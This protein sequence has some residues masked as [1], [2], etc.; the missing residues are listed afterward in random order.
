L[1]DTLTKK[2]RRNRA[3]A[4]RRLVILGATGSIGRSVADVI[5]ANPDS[6]VVEALVGGSNAPAL[7]KMAARLKARFAALADAAGYRQLAD[8]LA[9]TGV[10]AAA[11]PSAVVEAATR[12]SDLVVAAIVGTAGVAP[13][14]AA[15]EAG[16]T[17]ALANK[18]SLVCA[19]Y[20]F[21]EAARR[22]GV[23]VLPMDSEHNAI[24]QCLAGRSSRDVAK[25]TLTASGGP[26]RSW[27]AGRIAAA[28]CEEAVAHP[29][30]SMGAKISVDSAT[31]MNKGLELIEAHH[32][33]NIDSALLD[34]VVHP[35][36]I[37]HGLIE[38]RDGAVIAG[39]ANPDMRI[40]IAHC[41][42]YPERLATQATRLDLAQIG[43]LTF[44]Q[45]DYDR[46]PALGLARAALRHGDGMPTVLNAANE[47]AVA[48]FLNRRI[49]FPDIARTVDAACQAAAADGSARRPATVADALAVDHVV[50][51]RTAASLAV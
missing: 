48:A 20:P 1:N 46:F 9:G 42:G 34:V 10:A 41:L 25:M 13:T 12:P 3:G 38:F 43:A 28:T 47:I 26:F 36:S 8:L 45:P 35:Q 40:P 2:G 32:I 39:L 11:G 33:F 22:T 5:E 14:F 31:L 17:I 19:G 29:N 4:P 7:A 50:R 51:E 27:D 6:F 21:M 23:R 15:L 44:E 16:R 24:F 37:V 18:E 49:G 30:W